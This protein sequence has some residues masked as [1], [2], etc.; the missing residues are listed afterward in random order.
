MTPGAQR[1]DDHWAQAV[2]AFNAERYKLAALH[3]EKARAAR[4]GDA[5]VLLLLGQAL[6][7][8]ARPAQGVDRLRQALRLDPENATIRVTLASTLDEAGRHDEA[9]RETDAI[10]EADPGFVRAVTLRATLLRRTGRA[11][12]A[13]DWLAGRLGSLPESPA[14]AL[15][16]ASVLPAD[17]DPGPVLERLRASIAAPATRPNERRSL[18]YALANMLDRA[19]EHDA[20]FSAAESGARLIPDR[21]TDQHARLLERLSPERLASIE[22]ADSDASH[23]VLV[24][25]LPRSGTTLHEQILA[26][27]PRVATLGECPLINTLSRELVTH[28]EE[29]GL[30]PAE[31][32]TKLSRTYLKHAREHAPGGRHAGVILDKMPQN[33]V[34]LGVVERLLPGARVIRCS[35]DPRDNARSLFFMDFGAL[36]TYRRSLDTLADEILTFDRAAERWRSETRLPWHESRLEELTADP[37]HAARALVAFTGLEWDDACLRFHETAGHVRTASDTQIRSG[38]NTRGVGRWRPYAA[39]LAPLTKRLGLQESPD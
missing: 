16:L 8:S 37:E 32:T 27:H 9:L 38:I 18:F 10:L 3:A 4:P 21:N 26:A 22:P 15:S 31:L 14:L 23:V 36:H 11:R 39:H 12:E 29:H 33:L 34:H 20:A 24:C 17:A 13:W 2:G 5:R 7:R 30:A 25:G 1:A 35:R 28:A 6:A 19:G